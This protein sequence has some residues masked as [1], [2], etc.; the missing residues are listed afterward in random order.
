MIQRIIDSTTYNGRVEEHLT[1][2]A[3]FET[4]LRNKYSKS[5]IKSVD[6]A[7]IQKKFHLKGFTFGNYVTQEERFFFLFKIEKQ[8][9]FLAKIK[10]SNNLGLGKLIIGFGSFGKPRSLAHFNGENL[11]INLNRGRKSDYSDFLQGENSFIH[12]YG[13]FIDFIQGRK[14]RS[15]NVNFASEAASAGWD[16]PQIGKVKESS[17]AKTFPFVDFVWIAFLQTEYMDG[18]EKFS[19]AKYLM[20]N[21]EIYARLFET[22]V[23]Y[24]AHKNKKYK[25]FFEDRY[26]V[27][28]NKAVYLDK[29]IIEKSDA[30]KLVK[31]MLKA[32]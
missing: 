11:S 7:A 22:A 27:G 26:S 10:G 1:F 20:K 16:L 15:I 14:D 24:M 6:P 13:H 3:D 5:A 28:L 18:L 9:E 12:E 19:N 17:N 4:F 30:Y 31:Q 21:I 29:S 23:T 25:P 32:N 8:L 2:S